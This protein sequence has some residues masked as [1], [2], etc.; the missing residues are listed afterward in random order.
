MTRHHLYDDATQHNPVEKVPAFSQGR[1]A[2]LASP[3]S[4]GKEDVGEARSDTLREH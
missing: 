4:Y 1:W 2:L 3:T